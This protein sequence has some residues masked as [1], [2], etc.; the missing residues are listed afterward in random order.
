MDPANET[1]GSSTLRRVGMWSATATAFFAAVAFAVAVTTPPRTGPFAA[2][3]TAISYPYS[4]ADRFVPRDF[5]WMYLALAMMLAFVVMTAC[6]RERSVGSR[7]LFGTVGLSLATASFTVIAVDYFIQ[8]R[9]VQTSL[10]L[11]EGDGLARSF[12]STTRTAFSSPSKNSDSSW[13][14]YRFA[15]WRWLLALHASN[16]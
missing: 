4:A 8:L 12:R 11:G 13:A 15:S 16:G 2:S 3:A 14:G 1:F 10:V 6:V 7:R 5:I 9:T